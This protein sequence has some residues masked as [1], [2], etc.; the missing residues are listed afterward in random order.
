MLNT[1]LINARH[2]CELTQKELAKKIG[3]SERQYQRLEHGDSEGSLRN[4]KKISNVLKIPIEELISV[5]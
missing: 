2:E 1:K 4:W 3:I 5:N